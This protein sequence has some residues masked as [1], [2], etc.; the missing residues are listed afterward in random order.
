METRAHLCASD[1]TVLGRNVPA[2]HFG[3]DALRVCASWQE[4]LKITRIQF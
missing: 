4:M 1:A 2:L 3:P